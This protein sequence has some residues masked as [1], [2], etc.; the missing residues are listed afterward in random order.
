MADSVRITGD[1]SSIYN[2]ITVNTPY[3]TESTGVKVED[4]LQLMIAQL[5]NQDFLNPADDTQYVTQLAQFATMQSMQELSYYSQVNYV[6]NLVG[7]TVTVASLSLGG[8]VSKDVGIVSTVNLSGDAYTITVN[9]REY[10]LSQIMNV[11]ATG[12]TV[13]KKDIDNAALMV[14]NVTNTGSTNIK[15]KWDAPVSDAAGADSLSYDVYYTTDPSVDLTVLSNVKKGTAAAENL[16]G[17]EFELT[18]LEPGQ[19]YFISVVVRNT[20]GD[21]AIYQKAVVTTGQG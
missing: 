12:S 16:S 3:E 19:T 6:S 10:E 1:G 21:A 13:G 18:G 8:A 9:G 5:S 2:G 7:K 17:R 14:P 20:N 4:F 15:L 11:T